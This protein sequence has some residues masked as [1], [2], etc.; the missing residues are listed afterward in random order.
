MIWYHSGKEGKE[1]R[2]KQ[3][4]EGGSMDESWRAREK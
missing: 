4:R 3:K 2:S 1:N